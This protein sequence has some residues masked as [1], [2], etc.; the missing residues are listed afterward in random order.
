VSRFK[1][2]VPALATQLASRVAV[3]GLVA[4]IA[5]VLSG[6]GAGQISQTAT[7]E[8]AVDGNRVT[9][10]NNVAL[11]D[12]RIRA[13]QKTGDFIP[14]GRTV[15]LVLVAINLSPDTPDK[16]VDIIS[17]IGTVNISGDSRLPAGG[18]LFI[19][20][21]DGQKV[22][23][24]PLESNNAVRATVTLAKQ[25]TNG[26]SYNFTFIFENAGQT[27]VMVPVSAPLTPQQV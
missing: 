21:P 25:I 10:N 22:A 14:V 11:R 15:D 20:A 12:I 26:L 13:E 6:C 23:P 9:L 24:G 27:N 8:P 19:G 18:M 2:R 1:I 17:D 3:L 16:L 5:T 7:Q 4:M